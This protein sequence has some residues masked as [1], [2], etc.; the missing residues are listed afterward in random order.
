MEGYELIVVGAGHAGC[1]AALAAAR[2]G[3]ETLL[4]TL[5][6]DSVALMPCNPAIGGT[7]KGHLVREVDALGGEMGRCIDKTFLQSRMLNVGKGPAVYS[8][9]AQA[10]KRR[11]HEAMLSTLMST[12][13]LT[14]RQGEII[15]I[16][17]QNGRVTGAQTATGEL[18]PCR[19]IVLCCGV[20]LQSR[21]LIGE[22]EKPCGPQGLA[23]AEGLSRALE[24][25][26]FP[27]RRFKTGTPARIDCRSIDFDQMEPQVGDDPIIPFSFLTDAAPLR[28]QS[29]CYLTYTNEETHRIIRENLGLSPRAQGRMHGT[30]AR[31]C[32]SIEDKVQ[33]FAD[34]DRHQLFLEPEGLTSPEW[35]VQGMSTSLPERVQ[36]PMYRSV[37]GLHRAVLTRLAYAIEYDCIDSTQLYDTLQA[38]EI[39]G[40]FFAGQINGTSGYEE[41]AAQGILAGVNAACLLQG[42]EPLRITREMGYLGV[43]ADDLTVK[44]TDE[45]YRMMTSRAEHRLLLRQDNAD[46][47]LTALSHARGLATDERL[48]LTERKRQDGDALA[49]LLRHATLSP[50]PARAEWLAAHG[51]PEAQAALTAAELLRRPEISLRDVDALVPEATAY[52]APAREQAELNLKYEGYLQKEQEQVDRARAMEGR[53]LPAD[54][55]YGAIPSLRIEARQKLQQAR[56]ASLAQ[57]ARVRGVN[58]ADVAVLMV[59][60]KRYEAARQSKP[61]A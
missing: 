2:M 55:D 54:I 45:P 57:A 31:Y 25:L 61:T 8:L 13:R 56:P 21:I 18:I 26:G 19:A 14:L 52:S 35:Y 5:S 17:T 47:R 48:R 1:E 41:A 24:A 37:R 15:E 29:V 44:G 32:P 23:R 50:T 38:K 34:K 49:A 27:L 40:L 9:R 33:R 22:W 11:Y 43:M 39:G 46:L 20:Y 36:W 3:V 51:Q 12:D 4:L 16:Y 60:L 53:L 7:G 30:G 28:N 10:D 42:K 59:W 58:P 6:M